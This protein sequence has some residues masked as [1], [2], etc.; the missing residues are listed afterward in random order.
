MSK[1]YAA[2]R[3]Q[4]QE[5]P[6]NEVTASAF[7]TKFPLDVTTIP[8]AATP[9]GAVTYVAAGNGAGEIETVTYT[10]PDG[11]TK[12]LT[13]TYNSDNKLSAWALT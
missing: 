9:T 13:L 2:T 7:G 1:I 12:L 10:L 3:T 5:A 4:Q 6:S 8:V 11:S